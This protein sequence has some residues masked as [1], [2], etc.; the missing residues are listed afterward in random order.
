MKPASHHRN[1]KDPGPSTSLTSITHHKTR[2]QAPMAARRPFVLVRLR[3]VRGGFVNDNERGAKPPENRQCVGR[4][5][6]PHGSHVVTF[7]AV[8]VA[9]VLRI[10]L[11]QE[12]E[13]PLDGELVF[14][15][16]R[17]LRSAVRPLA[18][19]LLDQARRNRRVILECC[20][21]NCLPLISRTILHAW[22]LDFP[23]CPVIVDEVWWPAGIVASSHD[24]VSLLARSFG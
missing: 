5:Q 10:G 3:V 9:Q 23:D 2:S 6:P 18:R 22:A 24:S 19:R 20:L 11:L 12:T 7:V 13:R 4:D 14:R 16:V 15:V 1:T 17:F 21:A 8:Q